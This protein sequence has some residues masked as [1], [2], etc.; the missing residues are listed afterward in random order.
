MSLVATFSHEFKEIETRM[1]AIARS[2]RTTM[3]ERVAQTSF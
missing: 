3:R 1:P 2:L